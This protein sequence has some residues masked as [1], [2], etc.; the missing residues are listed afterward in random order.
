MAQYPPSFKIQLP[1]VQIP[2]H[3]RL[4]ERYIDTPYRFQNYH[5]AIEYARAAFPN[6]RLRLV[7]SQ[8]QAF[9]SPIVTNIRHL[10]EINWDEAETKLKEHSGYS[11]R[12][13]PLTVP[14]LGVPRVFPRPVTRIDDIQE[15][16]SDLILDE[17]AETEVAE[18]EVTKEAGLDGVENDWVD[19][20]AISGLQT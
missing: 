19:E 7:P 2:P 17:L 6:Y 12:I 5:E 8:D 1:F 16:G 14:D 13:R 9:W 3:L 10:Q 20:D 11:D 18:T 15:Q 4:E